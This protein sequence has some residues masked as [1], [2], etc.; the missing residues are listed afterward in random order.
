MDN[1]IGVFVATIAFILGVIACYTFLN[2]KLIEA[3]GTIQL[4]KNSIEIKNIV[5]KSLQKELTSLQFD[6]DNWVCDRPHLGDINT[7]MQDMPRF[8]LDQQIEEVKETFD[9]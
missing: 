7:L 3:N 5:T 1:S 9:I 6:L 4:L 8:T 2:N